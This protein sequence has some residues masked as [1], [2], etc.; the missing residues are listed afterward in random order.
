[1]ELGDRTVM[2]LVLVALF[3]DEVRAAGPQSSGSELDWNAI[4]P[5]R[6]ATWVFTVE[7]KGARIRR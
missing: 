7:E 1:M 6:F 2:L 4:E 3:E 5:S